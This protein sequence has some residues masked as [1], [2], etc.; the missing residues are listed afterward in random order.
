[1]IGTPH[2]TE[3]HEPEL[4]RCIKR[5]QPGQAAWSG[6]HALNETCARCSHFVAGK[7]QRFCEA[8]GSCSKFYT[9]TRRRGPTFEA[10]C[11]AC[12]YFEAKP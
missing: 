9:L 12:R 8:K 5:T 7:R 4:A 6:W 3:A 11:L 1:M 10:S 2:L